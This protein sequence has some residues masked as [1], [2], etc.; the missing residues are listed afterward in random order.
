MLPSEGLGATSGARSPE[1]TEFDAPRSTIAFIFRYPLEGSTVSQA[2]FSSG[3]STDG[4]IAVKHFKLK[5]AC[6]LSL[7]FG[8]C[9]A[10]KGVLIETFTSVE[11]FTSFEALRGLSASSSA[12][13]ALRAIAFRMHHCGSSFSSCFCL[14]CSGGGKK[15]AWQRDD[16]DFFGFSFPLAHYKVQQ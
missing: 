5:S 14:R 3:A 16:W 6:Q 13:L 15:R 10:S 12:S 11:R 7:D 4:W 2:R 9:A 1:A 8:N